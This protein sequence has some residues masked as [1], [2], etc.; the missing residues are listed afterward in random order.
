VIH[1]YRWRLGLARSEPQY[2]D[3]EAHLATGPIITVP[4]I[5]LEGDA[6]GAPHPEPRAYATRFAG[7]YVHRTLTVGTTDGAN[8]VRTN[9]VPGAPAQWCRGPRTCASAGVIAPA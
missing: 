4:T 7:P 5:T 6:N 2:D 9:L 3:L 1:N 8:H